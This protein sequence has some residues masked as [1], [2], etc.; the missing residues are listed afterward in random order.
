MKSLHVSAASPWDV[1][2]IYSY[3]TAQTHFSSQ[4][5]LIFSQTWSEFFVSRAADEA[6]F[7][8]LGVLL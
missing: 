4:V 8:W 3:F 2:N 1:Q 7:P 5:L 6:S